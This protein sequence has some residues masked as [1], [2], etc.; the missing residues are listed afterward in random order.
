MDLK[1]VF[2]GTDD[3]ALKAR[4][5]VEATGAFVG[6]LAKTGQDV[7]V[8]MLELDNTGDPTAIDYDAPVMDSYKKTYRPISASEIAK[9]NKQ[10]AEALAGENF[11]EGFLTAV[12]LIMMFK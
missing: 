11:V 10:M 9:A 7:E 4:S 8:S 5:F 3:L 12:Q 6:E 1:N 2:G